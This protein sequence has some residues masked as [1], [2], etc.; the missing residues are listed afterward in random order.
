MCITRVQGNVRF[1][2]KQTTNQDKNQVTEESAYFNDKNM[3]LNGI[4]KK[5]LNLQLSQM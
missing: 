4:F 1:W 2:I 5:Q 3:V